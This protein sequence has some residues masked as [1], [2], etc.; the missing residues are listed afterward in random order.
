MRRRRASRQPCLSLAGLAL[1]R[2]GHLPAQCGSPNHSVKGT[3]CGKSQ[4]APY[5]ER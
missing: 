4:A 5:V 3:S 1:A 2:S